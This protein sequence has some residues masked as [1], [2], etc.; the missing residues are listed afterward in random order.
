MTSVL[1]HHK[2]LHARK[3]VSIEL[4]LE[5][6]SHGLSVAY[7]RNNRSGHVHIRVNFVLVVC[8]FD[9]QILG[10][11]LPLHLAVRAPLLFDEQ[12][13]D[14]STSMPTNARNN[15]KASYSS[16]KSLNDRLIDYIV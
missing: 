16:H 8:D 6:S 4:L 2:K 12:V 9:I 15:L 13:K 1:T 3:T 7:G 5:F 11:F 14:V 10:V